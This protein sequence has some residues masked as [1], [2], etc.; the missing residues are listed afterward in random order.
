M[1]KPL[2][3]KSR[4]PNRIGEIF[5]SYE[6][7]Q[8][9][10]RGGFAEVYLGKHTQLPQQMAAIKILD[11]Q[12]IIAKSHQFQK[13]ASIVATLRHPNIVQMYDYNVYSNPELTRTLVPY[14]VMQYAPNKSLRVKHP[15]GQPLPI[16]TVLAYTGQIAGALQYAHEKGV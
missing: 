2:G 8:F 5:G 1:Q 12:L 11:K 6:L 10:G 14:I 15:R 9:L 16:K 4:M 7:V 3:A 13:E